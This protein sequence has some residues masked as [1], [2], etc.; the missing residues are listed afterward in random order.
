MVDEVGH[1]LR[2]APGVAV[3]LDGDAPDFDAALLAGTPHED[4]AVQDWL[5]D[6][7]RRW[8]ARRADR[9]SGLAARHEAAGALAAALALTEQLLVLEPLLEHAWRRLMRLH[10]LR[11][12]RGAAVAA[13]ERCERVLRDELGLAPSPE[14]QALL[15]QV[16]TLAEAAPPPSRAPLPPALLRPPRLVG[17]VAEREALAGAW[18]AGRAFLLVGEAGL[19]KSRLL[20]DIAQGR[21]RVLQVAALPGDETV[22]Y[23]LMLR[24]LRALAAGGPADALWPTGPAR[25]ELARLLPEL[26]PPP[27]L[28]SMWGMVLS[29]ACLVQFLISL[30]VDRRH[31]PHRIETFRPMFWVIWY[32]AAFWCLSAAATVVGFPRALL[33]RDGRRARW[34]SPDRGFR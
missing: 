28:L 23:A 32:P 27:A 9:M 12:D 33:R 15:A 25:Q 14:T 7:R 10:F 31:E 29:V 30:W 4:D 26:G 17:R 6:A 16:E 13:F 1:D 18:Q 20:A 2:L 19:G 34:T 21:E 8:L 11:G 24:L 5:D 22:S 3:D